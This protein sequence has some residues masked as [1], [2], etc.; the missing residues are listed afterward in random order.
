[1]EREKSRASYTEAIASSDTIARRFCLHREILYSI[2]C[3]GQEQKTEHT[4][5]FFVFLAFYRQFLFRLHARVSD[6]NNRGNNN[7]S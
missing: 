1:M 4:L 7:M 2:A 6:K 5:F 3:L